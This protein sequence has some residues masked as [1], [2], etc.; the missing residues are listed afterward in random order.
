MGVHGLWRLIEPSGKPVPLET[1]ENKVLAVDIS[2]WLHQA[3]KGF[4]DARGASVPNA[5]LLGIYHRVCKLLFFR[6]KPVFVFDGGVPVLKKQTIEKRVQTKLRM[7]S[8]TEDIQTQLLNTLIRHSAV[9][10]VLLEKI[11]ASTGNLPT[12]SAKSQK[13]DLYVLPASEKSSFEEESYSESSSES[14]PSKNWDLHTIDMNS[15]HF[16]SLPV[17]V[18]HEILTDLKETRKQNSWGKLHEMPKVSDD[19][20]EFQMKRLLKR[21]AVQVALEEAEKEMGGK[22]LSLAELE[23]LLTDQGVINSQKIGSRIASDENTK[24]LLVKDVKKAIEQAR[25]HEE[26]TIEEIDRPKN[27]STNEEIKEYKS[28]ADIEYEENLK[29]A[30]A[31]SLECEPITSIN[32]DKKSPAAQ[33]TPISQVSVDFDQNDFISSSSEEETELIETPIE[34]PK[35]MSSAQ[36]YM[37]EYS[38]LTPSEISKI[39]DKSAPKRGKIKKPQL[40]PLPEIVETDPVEIMS[41]SESENEDQNN[42]K[43]VV[44]KNI[45]FNEEDDLFADVF[46]SKELDI[47]IEESTKVSNLSKEKEPLSEMS[48]SN[49]KTFEEIDDSKSINEDKGTDI[50]KEPSISNPSTQDEGLKTPVLPNITEIELKVLKD[51]L[52]NEKV[53][54]ITKKSSTERMGSNITDQMYQE[55]QELLELFGV[56]YVIAPMEAEA[57]CAFLDAI[58]LTDGTITDDSDIWLFGGRTVYKNFFNQN[59]Y[60]KEFKAESIEHHFK[61]TREQMILLALLVGSD[62]T[63]GIQGVGPVTAMEILAAFP[64]GK[65][66]DVRMNHFELVSGLKE[67]RSWFIKGKSSGPGR[68]ALKRKLRDVQFPENFP[69]LQVVQGYMDPT[70]ETSEET[71]SWGHPNVLALIEFAREK[72]G[73]TKIKTEEILNPVIKKLQETAHQK[74]I[75]DYFK[76]TMKISGNETEEKMSKRVKK[77]IDNMSKSPSEVI[78]EEMK[79]ELKIATRGKRKIKDQTMAPEFKNPDVPSVRKKSDRNVDLAILKPTVSEQSVEEKIDVIRQ[80]RKTKQLKNGHETKKPKLTNEKKSEIPKELQ[81]ELGLLSQIIHK[82]NVKVQEI[83]ESMQDKLNILLSKQEEMSI[84]STSKPTRVPRKESIP[85]KERNQTMMLRNKLKAIE[86]FR[87]GKHGPGFV[88][89]RSKKKKQLKEDAELSESSD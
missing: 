41:N 73:W 76:T 11:E 85:Q 74:L 45:Q 80:R 70:V 82:S 58:N 60:V 65:V 22:S 24:Y 20:S 87:K 86:V 10:K 33:L 7:K 88:A 39:V 31:L 51:Q 8:K 1:L 29:K 26:K 56:P 46:V 50:T 16:K 9:S 14:S 42:L 30:I 61:L 67:F 23:S 72:F 55:A 44:D 62:Y 57:Q 36:N 21:Q 89:K 49:D 78:A 13:A 52:Q 34:K 79:Q 5:H 25:K 2:I 40:A 4:Q 53:E 38:G 83:N 47:Q 6:I 54:L 81:E 27:E 12:V 75:K 19:F 3:V 68:N 43:I 59:K 77:A 28:K 84:A 35:T 32:V 17:D 63:V 69:S 71:F 64:A 18:K 15:I 66:H 48:T 37:L